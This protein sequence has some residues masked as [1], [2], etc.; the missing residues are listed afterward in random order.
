MDPTIPK[1]VSPFS[2]LKHSPSPSVSSNFV[3]NPKAAAGAVA[4]PTGGCGY[5]PLQAIFGNC[6]KSAGST[7][8]GL[9]VFFGILNRRF[10]SPIL[11]HISLCNTGH[12]MLNQSAS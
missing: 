8:F 10:V 2:V 12:G 11:T 1:C 5:Y 9:G 7:G 3:V 6:A 4:H